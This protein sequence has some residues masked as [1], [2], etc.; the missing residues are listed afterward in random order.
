MA[1][2]IGIIRISRRSYKGAVYNLHLESDGQGDDLFW[3]DGKSGIIV[4]N[5]LPKDTAN[6]RHSMKPP[7]SSFLYEVERTNAEIRG[8]LNERLVPIKRTL[9]NVREAQRIVREAKAK[10]IIPTSKTDE[11]EEILR[12]KAQVIRMAHIAS[13]ALCDG[14][15]PALSSGLLHVIEEAGFGEAANHYDASA[16]RDRVE[17]ALQEAN[18][19]V[20]QAAFS[21]AGKTRSTST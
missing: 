5:C 19:A 11:N 21:P 14:L 2:A 6:L 4:H 3:I 7:C 18:R 13:K 10:T 15:R 1:A 8:E 9:D 16:I 17:A 12:L 20:A